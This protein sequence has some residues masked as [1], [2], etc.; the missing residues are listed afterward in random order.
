MEAIER[1]G[2]MGRQFE[3]EEQDETPKIRL[4]RAE[5]IAIAAKSRGVKPEQIEIK[6]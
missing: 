1:Q 6:E 5:L 4:T 2:S 3:C